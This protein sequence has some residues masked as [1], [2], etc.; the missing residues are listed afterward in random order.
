MPQIQQREIPAR[1]FGP[2]VEFDGPADSTADVQAFLREHG[3][4][5]FRQG[6]DPDSVLTAR[7]E[8]LTRLAD[9]GEVSEP[10]MD[11]RMTGRSRRPDP[12]ED[13]GAFWKSVNH[14]AA[15]R[16]VTHGPAIHEVVATVLGEAPRVH[17]LMYLRPMAPGKRRRVLRRA[18]V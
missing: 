18:C 7:K 17:D 11:G 9:V 3:Y 1:R 6:L 12:T 8:V 13:R 15:L 14:G 5:V 4:I 2:L 10:I 16:E